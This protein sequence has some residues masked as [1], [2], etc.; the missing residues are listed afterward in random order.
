L[1]RLRLEKGTFWIFHPK[2]EWQSQG[3]FT[4]SGHHIEFFNDPHCHQD[5]GR[6]GWK[7]E[8]GQ[9]VL[10]F[11][12]DG[13]GFGLRATSLTAQPWLA[14]QPSSTEAAISDHWPKPPGCD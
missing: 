14:C 2:T 4:I 8:A 5:V 3:S 7:L 1:W 10:E 12:D 6:Y 11:I 13:C 9:L